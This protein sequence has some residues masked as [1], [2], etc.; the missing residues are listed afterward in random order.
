MLQSTEW[1]CLRCL[2][3]LRPAAGVSGA[4]RT[5]PVPHHGS[6]GSTAYAAPS[7]LPHLT[8]MP[9]CMAFPGASDMVPLPIEPGLDW[10]TVQVPDG[11]PWPDQSGIDGFLGPEVGVSKYNAH[12]SVAHAVK[13]GEPGAACISQGQDL[14]FAKNDFLLSPGSSRLPPQL[15]FWPG[16]DM[17][18]V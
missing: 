3:R 4:V 14:T 2:C 7:T 6:I 5:S 9:N 18:G 11:V 13:H 1:H 16:A 17:P 15:D 12:M 8:A 10:G